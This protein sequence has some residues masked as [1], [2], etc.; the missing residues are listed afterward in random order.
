MLVARA[1][2]EDTVRQLIK[3]GAD[4]S[5]TDNRGRSALSSALAAGHSEVA[6]SLK[7]AGARQ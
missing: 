1:G 5:A 6:R 2:R 4:V 3:A 7:Q